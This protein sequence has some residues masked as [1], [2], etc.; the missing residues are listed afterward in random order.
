MAYGGSQSWNRY[1][2]HHYLQ[3]RLDNREHRPVHFSWSQFHIDLRERIDDRHDLLLPRSRLQRQWQ[4]GLFGRGERHDFQWWP[5]GTERF[6]RND[7][8]LHA[9]QSGLDG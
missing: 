4:L 5:R 1:A 9:D 8:Q 3:W 7:V 6:D 2:S